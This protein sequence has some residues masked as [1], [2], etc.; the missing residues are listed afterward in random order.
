MLAHYA[1]LLAHHHAQGPR[2]RVAELRV[3]IEEQ[4][5]EQRPYQHSRH[6]RRD[7]RQRKGILAFACQKIRIQFQR[8]RHSICQVLC[9]PIPALSTVVGVREPASLGSACSFIR[10]S[11]DGELYALHRE[12]TEAA[13]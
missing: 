6:I 4:T 13:C 12:M 7:N 9:M 10:A 8:F 2:L 1:V 11:R 3:I 5:A